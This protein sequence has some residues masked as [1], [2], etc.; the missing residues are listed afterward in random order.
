MSY[1]EFPHT[2]DYEGDLGY[3][4]KKLAELTA[5]YDNF[6]AYNSIRFHNPIN[7]DITESYPAWNIVYDEQSETLY[8]SSKEVPA[9]IDISNGDYW[10]A[11]SPFKIDT[12]LSPVS[13]N[14]VANKTLATIIGAINSTTAQLEQD[15]LEEVSRA[16]N[17]EVRLENAINA[18]TTNIAAE[19]VNRTSE[20]NIINARIDS[21]EALPDGS[22]T[23]DAELVDIRIGA[24][25]KTYSAAGDAV[26]DQVTYLQDNLYNF[27]CYDILAGLMARNTATSG[28][29]TFT[30][31]YDSCVVTA[32]T[33][34]NYAIN[35]I[36]PLASTL[37]KYVIPGNTY[38]V[39]YST[40]DNKVSLRFRF[41]NSESTV[42]TIYR[43]TD[44]T[45]TV[46][47][48]TVTWDVSLFVNINTTLANNV[49]VSNIHL[50][51]F[52]SLQEIEAAMFSNKYTFGTSIPSASDLD[53]YN[54][55]GDYYVATSATAATIL[56]APVTN[57]TY[58]LLVIETTAAD[59]LM[60]IAY[61]NSSANNIKMAMRNKTAS[62]WTAWQQIP[63][64]S[65]IDEVNNSSIK[66]TELIITSSNYLD[67]FPNGSF[68]DA[69][70]N[71]IITISG[72]VPLTDGPAGNL[73]YGNSSHPSSGYIR[74][75]LMTYRSY[76]KSDTPRSG[77][78][79]IM[80]G[81]AS[82]DNNP[83]NMASISIRN[84]IY[85]EGEIIWSKWSKFV[86]NG[87]LHSSN[88]F[89]YAGYLNLTFDDLDDMP[90]NSIVQIDLNL[91]G[92]DSDHTLGHHPAPGK[93]CVAMCYAYAY[94]TNHGKVQVVYTIDG[95]MYW[96]YG[97]YQ[98]ADDY[99][100]TDW[101]NT[102]SNA[103]V[104][105]GVLA[106]ETDLNTV[107]SN[108]VYMLSAMPGAGYTHCP[109]TL[110]ASYLTTKANGV[111]RFQ[112]VEKLTGE[113]YSRYSADSGSTW[114]TW[115]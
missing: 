49:T 68:N 45:V 88:M 44:S 91:N 80:I 104:N 82:P 61:I 100:W 34:T 77:L 62:G 66:T 113:R 36:V 90:N 83:G 105:E 5:A 21:I 64:M 57:T 114:S 67:T 71:S 2:R 4:I 43:T 7:W 103:L 12:E 6:F 47:A 8:I 1:F 3:I 33:S 63:T 78:T 19:T 14:P 37:S 72:N 28:G 65:T 18:N 97:Y 69:P 96:R 102:A 59:R 42:T 110:G 55:P 101:Y 38:K 15:I 26:R 109:V 53:N 16:V 52:S 29:I 17:E 50:L 41:I 56:N 85:S 112:T 10:A 54:T 75:T 70:I 60:Q 58:R 76:A 79:Q 108:S 106:N 107:L 51:Q 84:A 24:N 39:K 94:D 99:R 73:H 98:S 11:V 48:D 95:I 35:Y 32:G 27:N 25:G 111:V 30:W 74:G 93:S 115:A 31:G 87:Y 13:I 81:Y 9:G 46:P 89:L 86:E 92:S 23:A 20:D 40:T 22:T